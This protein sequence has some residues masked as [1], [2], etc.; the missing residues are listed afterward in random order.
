MPQPART[1]GGCTLCCR[2]MGIAALDKPPGLW[3]PN[4]NVG[5]SCK[6]YETRPREC[7]EFNCLWLK[8]ENLDERWKPST[9]K[10]CLVLEAGRKRLA[11]HVDPNRPDAWKR[12][13]Y[14]SQLKAWA[15]SYVPAGMQVVV[16]I[17]AR[18]IAILPGRDVDLGAVGEDDYIVTQAAASGRGYD[19]FV[20]K[21]D[22]DA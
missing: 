15:K 21:T 1:C 5:K 18:R 2:V 3:C 19:A 8:D 6:V 12:E 20:S 16:G 13:P 14:Y 22:P 7:R 4:C 9:A 17:G 10:F 11:A